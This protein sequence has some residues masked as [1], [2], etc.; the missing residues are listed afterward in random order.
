MDSATHGG[1]LIS[2]VA[3]AQISVDITQVVTAIFIPMAVDVTIGQWLDNAIKT[4]KHHPTNQ[5]V[6]TDWRVIGIPG[7]VTTTIL[8]IVLRVTSSIVS[9][10]H[11][12]Q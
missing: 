10:I 11:S 7:T 8:I 9:A 4:S 6:L 1:R 2:L 5:A 12:R 3:L